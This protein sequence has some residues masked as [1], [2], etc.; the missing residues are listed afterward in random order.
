[1]QVG[2]RSGAAGVEASIIFARNHGLWRPSYESQP[3]DQVCYGWAGPGSAPE[4]MHTGLIVSRSGGSGSTAQTVEGNR[5]DQ[6]ERQTFIVGEFVVLGTVNLNRLFGKNKIV[7][8]HPK[9]VPQPRHP[10]HLKNTG[11]G[12]SPLHKDAEKDAE[13]LEKILVR[14]RLRV[15]SAAGARK[16]LKRL[17]ATIRRVLNIKPKEHK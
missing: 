3:G 2:I 15:R 5:S 9:P 7:I 8:H 1:M 14:R 11:P 13:D 4:N 16:L 12:T 17:R 10:D 6:V